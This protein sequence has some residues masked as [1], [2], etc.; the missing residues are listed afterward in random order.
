MVTSGDQRE[1]PPPE[2]FQFRIRDL[3]VITMLIGL[4]MA[5]IG[6]QSVVLFFAFISVAALCLCFV[7]RKMTVSGVLALIG[8]S[9]LLLLCGGAFQEPRGPG[10]RVSCGNNLKQIVLALHDYHDVYGSLPPTYIAYLLGPRP[11][12]PKSAL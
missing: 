7:W 11:T 10:R 8:I 5:A 3:L 2:P 1:M 6:Q 9:G 4:L 12:N